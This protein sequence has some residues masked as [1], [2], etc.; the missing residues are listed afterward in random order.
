MYKLFVIEGNLKYP[1]YC[2]LN[3]CRIVYSFQERDVVVSKRFS[4][5]WACGRFP[6]WDPVIKAAMRSYEGTAT[7]ED[8][9]LL[10]AEVGRFLEFA[11]GRI[12]EIRDESAPDQSL[13]GTR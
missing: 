3:L 6:H 7:P 10:D 9:R 12:R 8:V 4:G 2:I 1:A 5:N 13:Q 11:S